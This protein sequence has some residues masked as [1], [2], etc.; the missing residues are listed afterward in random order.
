V[1]RYLAAALALNRC[2]FGLGYLL[3]P[4]RMGRGWVDQAAERPATQVMIRGLGARDLSLGIG[5][6]WS[7]ANDEASVR[8]WFAAHALSDAADLVATVAASKDLPP[9]RVAF[10]GAMAGVSTAIALAAASKA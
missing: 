4:A 10:A 2:A 3:A 9:R 1:V 5:A 7:I 8:P 6:L